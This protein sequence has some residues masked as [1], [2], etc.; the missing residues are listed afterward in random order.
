MAELTP[1][2][3]TK[4]YLVGI[5]A[6][7]DFR[8]LAFLD[9][10]PSTWTCSLC[11]VTPKSTVVLPCHV[12]C[13]PCYGKIVQ[14]SGTKCPL[15][16]STFQKDSVV[17]NAVPVDQ[18]LER[19]VRCWNA[20]HGCYF[21]GPL[22]TLSEHVQ[23]ECQFCTV[24]CTKCT[25]EVLRSSMLDHRLRDCEDETPGEDRDQRLD[26][27]FADI[28]DEGK[29]IGENLTSIIHN[30]NGIREMVTSLIEATGQSAAD[31]DAS[32]LQSQRSLAAE[33]KQHLQNEL[34][35]LKQELQVLKD[36]L[37]AIPHLRTDLSEVLCAHDLSSVGIHWKIK[38]FNENKQEATEKGRLVLGS[39]VFQVSG[40]CLRL[41]LIW[42]TIEGVL[43]LQLYLRLCRGP[44][45]AKL[46]WPFVKPYTL[47]LIHPRDKVKTKKIRVDPLAY[48]GT[49]G[50]F[51]RPQTAQ[52]PGVGSVKL[53]RV[54][55]LKPH[56][57]VQDDSVCVGVQIET[58]TSGRRGAGSAAGDVGRSGLDSNVKVHILL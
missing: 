26:A 34:A 39:D 44:N 42:N 38:S 47:L 25:E 8:P 15:D 22:G 2:H 19:T 1:I 55:D 31:I 57:F 12:F 37:R 13:A 29:H 52:N 53:Y 9:P 48:G 11:G 23:K 43:A 4:H 46:D 51:A 18:V 58:F 5:S 40:Y 45:D 54:G 16:L 32:S 56:G 36:S 7:L 17:H 49:H 10:L 24:Q 30:Q 27:V 50:P 33:L 28:R 6:E 20:D 3:P 14:L 41:E 35:P 21:V